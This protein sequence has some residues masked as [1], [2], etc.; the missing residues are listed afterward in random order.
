M[1][2][3]RAHCPIARINKWIHRRGKREGGGG[4]DW[5]RLRRSDGVGVMEQKRVR[6]HYIAPAACSRSQA[7]QVPGSRL[8]LPGESER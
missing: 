7:W 8:Q 1:R 5:R 2:R 4:V 3:L 6:R